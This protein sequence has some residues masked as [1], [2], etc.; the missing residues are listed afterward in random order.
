M[1]AFTC[2]VNCRHVPGR[3]ART[4]PSW[5][6]VSR[7]STLDPESA[8]ISTHSLSHRLARQGLPDVVHDAAGLFRRDLD[9]LVLQITALG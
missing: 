1:S 5:S 2:P 8:A 4:G 6:L 7:T 3:N 9:K